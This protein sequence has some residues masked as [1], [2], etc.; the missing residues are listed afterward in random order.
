MAMTAWQQTLYY[1]P[2]RGCDAIRYSGFS[3]SGVYWVT[4]PVTEP[5][6]S[7]RAQRDR[8]LAWL[9][10]AIERGDPPGEVDGVE[11]EYLRGRSAT[12][13]DEDADAL[14]RNPEGIF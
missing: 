8:V 3:G 11:M 6:K 10:I 5:G 14:H 4:E 12:G 7:R 13:Q 2:I 1:D 9:E